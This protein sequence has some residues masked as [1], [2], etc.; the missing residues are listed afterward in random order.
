VKA[1]LDSGFF[2]VVNHGISEEVM[3][4]VFAQSRRMFGLPLS[5]K[6]RLLRNEKHRG[7]TPV[8][9]EVLD[10]ENQVHGLFLLPTFIYTKKKKITF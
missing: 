3:D 9:D 2:Y 4:K 7:Y 5:E 6:M 10:P 8:L 1:C